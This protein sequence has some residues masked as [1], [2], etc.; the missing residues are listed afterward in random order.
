[1]NGVVWCAAGFCAVMAAYALW[2]RTRRS[3]WDVDR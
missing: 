1:M 3:R 2:L